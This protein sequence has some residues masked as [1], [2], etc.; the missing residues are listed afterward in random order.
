MKINWIKKHINEENNIFYQLC[1]FD[2]RRLKFQK[3]EL[4]E[5]IDIILLIYKSIIKNWPTNII[6]EQYHYEEDGVYQNNLLYCFNPME[7]EWKMG[8]MFKH[9][10]IQEI[11][12]Y[13]YKIGSK[14][15]PTEIIRST[16]SYL[17]PS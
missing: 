5:D 4:F 16:S 13:L 3:T 11:Y 6:I 14:R 1:S 12:K 10:D 7:R 9:K 8:F 15:Y 2:F 17:T